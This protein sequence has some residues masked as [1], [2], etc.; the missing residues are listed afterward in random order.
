MSEW[1][2]VTLG[3]VADLLVGFAF[4]S[5]RFTDDESDPRLLR[6]VNIGQGSLDWSR[7]ARWP[8]SD[9]AAYQR[10]ELSDGDVVLAMDRPW[11][12]AGLKRARIRSSDLPALLVQRVTRMRGTE[13]A[14]TSFIH[15]LVGSRRF[16]DYIKP[17]VTG[18]NVPHIS[19]DQIKA[20]SFR[21][22]A[23]RTQDAIC[24]VLDAIENL[25]ENNRRRIALLERMAQAIYREWFMHVRYPGH[26]DDELVD[27]P[28]GPI[29]VGWQTSTFSELGNYL[30]GFAFN[31]AHWGY[32]GLPIVKIK[33]L[34]QGVTPSTRRYSGDDIGPKYR[35]DTGDLLF[36]WSAHLDAYLWSGGPALLNQHLFKV[37]P[38]YGVSKAWLY[39]ALRERMDEFRSRSQGTTMKHIKRAALAEV[40]TVTPPAPVMQAFDDAVTPVLEEL[41]ALSRVLRPLEAIRAALLPKLVT[42]AIDVS[43]LDLNALLEESPA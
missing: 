11:I 43:Q 23:V 26:E 9:R 8:Q 29:P 33:E 24:S 7:C 19:P 14:R 40:L 28:L 15:H 1:R 6:G 5:A 3:E 16:S 2:D 35:I 31:P 30:N 34:K 10:Y 37:S 17:I 36:S 4:K 32:V 27:S 12:E 21:L 22:P 18:V 38:T 39:L 25:S 42:G 41:L 20:F 13:L